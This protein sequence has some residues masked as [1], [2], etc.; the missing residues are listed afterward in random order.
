MIFDRNFDR[1]RN[2]ARTVYA[3]ENREVNRDDAEGT[4]DQECGEPTLPE[5]WKKVVE[6]LTP[7]PS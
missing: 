5:G 3:F 6:T 1:G 2:P 4:F 7:S